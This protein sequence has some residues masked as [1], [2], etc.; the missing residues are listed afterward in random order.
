V[1]S[2]P[3]ELPLP[4]DVTFLLIHLVVPLAGIV[5]FFRL[6]RRLKAQG[7]SPGVLVLLFW[8]FFCWGGVVVIG[9]T[10]LFWSWSGMASLGAFFV[11]FISPF[12]VLPAT[13]GVRYLTRDSALA[14]SAW[15]SCVIYYIL[16]GIALY[17]FMVHPGE[18][19]A[20][21]NQTMQ[22]TASPRTASFF[23]D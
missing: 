4:K 9:L 1:K 2:L 5:I 23:D 17:F 12:V 20:G 14:E 19:H 16:V 13:I 7:E 21:S 22:P 18:K 10:A 6:C 8:L 11:L 3:Y 15:M